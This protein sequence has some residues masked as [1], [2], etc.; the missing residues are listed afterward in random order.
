MITLIILNFKG[1]TLDY[2][3]TKFQMFQQ[4]THQRQPTGP[5]RLRGAPPLHT[6][7]THRIE[8]Q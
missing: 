1:L 3:G 7:C 5:T 4:P 8:C 2:F 6:H